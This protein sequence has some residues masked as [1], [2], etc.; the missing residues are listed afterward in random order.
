M[1]EQYQELIFE[2]D[3][4]TE[5][6]EQ[7]QDYNEQRKIFVERKDIEITSLYDRYKNGKL[8]VQ[9]EYQRQYVWDKPKASR[10]IESVLLDVPLP[11]I[12]LSEGMDGKLSVIDGQQRL[13]SFFAYFDNLFPDKSEFKLTGLRA[14]S[15]LKNKAYKYLDDDKQDKI[16]QYGIP[17]IIFKKESDS[18]LKFE[19][20]ERLNTGS[21]AL[22][23]QELRNCIF[24][25]KYNE[26]LKKMAQIPEYRVNLA[27][28]E[29][30]KRMKD[31]EYALRFS[32]FYHTSY[33][34]FVSPMKRF[35][36]ND[37]EK[38]QNITDYDA[39]ELF[40]AFKQANFLVHSVFGKH[41]FKKYK[42][43]DNNPNQGLWEPT[44]INSSLYDIIMYSFAVL[45]KE[46][47]IRYSDKI[48]DALINLMVDD[49]DFIDSIEK[50]T[51][52][53]KQV[54]YRFTTWMN[55]VRSVTE[56]A[57]PQPRCFTYS[58]KKQM[59]EADNTCKICNNKIHSIDDAAVDHIKPYSEGGMTTPENA[60]LTHRYCN[61]SRP[62]K[63]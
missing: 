57:Q 11:M 61:W 60:R 33:D 58:L 48:R 46:I 31:I 8:I 9:P 26:L 40:N 41:A 63:E 13:A 15:D 62:R 21:V 45:N 16:R 42:R 4:E 36:N 2:E 20:F 23:D 34:R 5:E 14:L 49:Q 30:E 12:Y 10:L 17:V 22:N 6:E 53:A 24:R 51:S 32:A 39:Q 43:D 44:I 38:Y 29:T 59:F 50:A 55:T 52:S 47:I 3:I 56:N 54:H 28:K 27:L 1:D 18:E 35:L 7:I 25:G 37:M 19:V